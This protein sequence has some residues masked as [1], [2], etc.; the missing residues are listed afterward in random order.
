MVTPALPII[1]KSFLL[2]PGEVEW[3]VSTFLIGYVLGQLIY[4]PLANRYGRL[5]SLKFGL[6]INLLGLCICIFAAIYGHFIWLLIGRFITGLGSAAGLTC[7]LILINE[8]LPEVKR[9]A[10]MAYSVLSFALGVGFAVLI[11]GLITQYIHWNGCFVFLFLQGLVLRIGVCVFEETLQTPMYFNIHKLL[12][13]YRQ[14]MSSMQLMV[15]SA[16]WGTCSAMGYCFAAAGPQIAHSYLQLSAAEYGYWN[17]LN[18]LGMV[19]GGLSARILLQNLPTIYVIRC[20]YTGCLLA[21]LSLSMMLI[22][23]H[24]STLWFFA[25]SCTL[26]WF[27]AYLFAGGS[28]VA[29]AA[30]KD[31]AS[32][33]SMMS[34]VNMGIA[35]LGVIIM[36]CLSSDP[37]YGF[38]ILV[39]SFMLITLGLSILCRTINMGTP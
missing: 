35:T 29:S 17:M 39:S 7:T 9:K 6:N 10:A 31:K 33:S 23:K 4:G 18:L 32:A 21:L 26:Y 38:V 11:G 13:D 14:A 36:P 1:E 12:N 25:S 27:S 16:V 37:F 2:K 34:F 5:K 8:W 19:L 20:G 3:I 28:Y 22:I 24:Y 15:F 30:I